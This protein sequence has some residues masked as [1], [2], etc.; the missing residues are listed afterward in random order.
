MR[1]FDFLKILNP[2]LKLAE[3]KVHLATPDKEGNDPLDLYSNGKFEKWQCEQTQKNFERK[4]V[5]SLIDLQTQDQW[6][7]AGVYHSGGAEESKD[8]CYYELTEDPHCKE[9]NGRL[10]VTFSD[11]WGYPYR[12]A[13][14]CS[15]KILLLREQVS[16]D[17]RIPVEDLAIPDSMLQDAITICWEEIETTTKV[18]LIN[19]RIGQGRF[20]SKVLKCWGN[21]CAVTRS[22]TLDAIRASHIKP[23]RFSTNPERL[24]PYNGLPLVASLDALFDAGLICFEASGALIVSSKL[25]ESEREIF[26]VNA[27]SSLTKTPPP[28]TEQ[29][30]EY[31]RDCVF[32]K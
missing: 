8:G 29:Y 15:D 20:R 12:D 22:E 32:K 30:L 27:S 26:G 31:H 9:M 1:I 11:R 2:S 7:F 17:A 18:N 16:V 23:W 5:L 4:F 21:R 10:V 28:G 19:A 14:N 3:T 25:S 6:L 13:E 24:D